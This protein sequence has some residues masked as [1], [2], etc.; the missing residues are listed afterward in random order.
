MRLNYLGRLA[1]ASLPQSGSNMLPNRAGNDFLNEWQ[2]HAELLS[3]QLAP[4]SSLGYSSNLKHFCFGKLNAWVGFARWAMALAMAI[5][6]DH[7]INVVLLRAK[8]EVI[9]TDTRGIIAAMENPKIVW[10]FAIVKAIRVTVRHRIDL[11]IKKT[12]VPS[13]CQSGSIYPTLCFENGV[14]RPIL[15]NLCQKAFARCCGL[16]SGRLMPSDVAFWLASDKSECAIRAFSNRGWLPTAAHA[17]A[18]WIWTLFAFVY[19]RLDHASMVAK[20]I[21][22]W[23]SFCQSLL[24]VIKRYNRCL[25]AAPASA[26]A[27]GDF[28]RGF[29][30][31]IITHTK[32]SLSEFGHATERFQS[33]RWRFYWAEYTYSI[34]QIFDTRYCKTLSGVSCA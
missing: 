27:I 22:S 23:L 9:G 3:N 7:V 1:T 21:S 8:K 20:D 2:T 34:A 33:L 31:G 17:Q 29:V 6:C 11:A 18:A 26:I 25:L 12:S 10:Y 19:L 15:I 16:W 14:N 30:R 4:G 28:I 5:L 24:G 32:F 13:I